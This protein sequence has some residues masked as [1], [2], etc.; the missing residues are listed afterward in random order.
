MNWKF[1]SICQKSLIYS[2]HRVQTIFGTNL[3]MKLDTSGVWA[4]D[5]FLCLKLTRQLSW[6]DR[7]FLEERSTTF[8]D[9]NVMILDKKS[10]TSKDDVYKHWPYLTICKS[11]VRFIG[12]DYIIVVSKSMVG[13]IVYYCCCSCKEN[14]GIRANETWQPLTFV[15]FKPSIVFYYRIRSML[16]KV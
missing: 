14:Y 9:H 12:R 7:N 5:V 3:E 2:S 13:I 8:E 10:I 15:I 1:H 11:I 6:R 4:N 16:L